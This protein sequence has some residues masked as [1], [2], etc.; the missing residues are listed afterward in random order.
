MLWLA[1]LWFYNLILE[2]FEGALDLKGLFIT[3]EGGEGAGKST[4]IKLLADHLQARGMEVVLTREPGGTPGAEAVRI[5]LLSGEAEAMGSLAEAGLFAAARRDHVDQVI[6]P[7]LKAGK[8]VLCDRFIDSTRVYQG[9]TLS[10]D[11][12]GFLEDC[13]I[14]DIVPQLTFVLDLPADIGMRRAAKR[15]NKATKKRNKAAK[16]DRFEKDTLPIQEERRLAFLS[17]AAG[18]PERCKVV[19]ATL[20]IN[21]IAAEIAEITDAYMNEHGHVGS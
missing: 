17:I 16:V 13:A 18:E 20:P 4:Q 2:Q 3:F 14:G 21:E 11:I 12:L 5:M 19:D 1:V 15:R 8:A 10:T 7:A 9:A 6:A